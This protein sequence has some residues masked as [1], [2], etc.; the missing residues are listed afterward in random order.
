M[1]EHYYMIIYGTGKESLAGT[2]NLIANTMDGG[3]G[4]SLQANILNEKEQYVYSLDNL[5]NS[6]LWRGILNGPDDVEEK[7]VPEDKIIYDGKLTTHNEKLYQF[8]DVYHNIKYDGDN[9]VAHGYQNSSFMF[10]YPKLNQKNSLQ[11][12]NSNFLTLNPND[13]ILIPIVVEYQVIEGEG[14]PKIQKSIS[15]D[16][17][18]SLY[19]DP[20]NYKVTFVAKYEHTDQDKIMIAQQTEYNTNTS[21]YNVIYK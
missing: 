11:I 13:E 12:Q 18:T 20:T 15:F 19:K 14:N 7:E 6:A 17:L 3:T 16:I 2:A 9:D 8:M 21:K 10:V 4:G 5:L 1:K